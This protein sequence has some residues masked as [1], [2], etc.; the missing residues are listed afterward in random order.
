V[1]DDWKAP[2]L[3][4]AAP[5]SAGR[6]DHRFFAATMCNRSGCAPIFMNTASLNLPPAEGVFAA[7]VLG[8]EPIE[9]RI[10]SGQVTLSGR[11]RSYY[12]KQ[13]A[14]ESVRRLAGVSSVRNELTVGHID[15]A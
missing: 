14:Q 13:M 10:D 2:T 1:I 5:N 6:R 7:S 9:V 11:V 15:P 4:A 3:P 8:A 12:F